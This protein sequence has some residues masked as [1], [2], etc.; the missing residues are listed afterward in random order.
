MNHYEKENAKE[1]QMDLGDAPEPSLAPTREPHGGRGE[2]GWTQVVSS[3]RAPPKRFEASSSRAHNNK[4]PVAQ[5]STPKPPQLAKDNNAG[6]P[7]GPPN[8]KATARYSPPAGVTG[9]SARVRYQT[10]TGRNPPSTAVKGLPARGPNQTATPSGSQPNQAIAAPIISRRDPTDSRY[11]TGIKLVRKED[12][13]AKGAFRRGKPHNATFTLSK[14]C[15]R[16]EPDRTEMYNRLEEIGVRFGSFIRPPQSL[17]DR[18]LLLWGDEKQTA[19]TIVELM[20]WAKSS[21]DTEGDA[22]GPREKMQLKLKNEKFARVGFS[23]N[24]KA[25]QLDRKI[26]EEA[27]MHKYQKDPDDGKEF[28]FQGCFL[29]PVDEVRPEELLGPN[30]EAFDPIRTYNHSHI[31][32]EPNLSGFKIL[33]NKEAAVQNAIQRIE[34]TMREYVARSGKTY[35]SYMVQLPKA[36]N[37]LKDVM[38]V[39]GPTGKVPILTGVHLTGQDVQNYMEEKNGIESENRKRIRH[40]FRRVIERLPLYRGQVRMRVLFGTLTLSMFRWPEGATRVPFSDFI[41]HIDVTSTKGALIRE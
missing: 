4:T 7:R 6:S 35:S 28:G 26:Q 27:R 38:M 31:I 25:E 1:W 17:A 22:H 41:R 5:R 23:Q 36:S 18:T 14:T 15:D 21:H 13:A 30:C 16:V 12:N 32:F 3:R 33:S 20:E 8:Q 37:M 34:G 10:V 29:W 19:P 40:A 11:P 9:L 2:G 39:P 24:K